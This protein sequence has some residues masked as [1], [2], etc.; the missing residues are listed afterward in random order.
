MSEFIGG[1]H[2]RAVVE[3]GYWEQVLRKWPNPQIIPRRAFERMDKWKEFYDYLGFSHVTTIGE[4]LDVLLKYEEE[5]K[6]AC[7]E[8]GPGWPSVPAC[9]A[10]GLATLKADAKM[11]VA[12]K[13]KK[14][15]E[16]WM[17]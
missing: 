5:L 11:S 7:R 14:R 10:H 12:R 15:R 1:I 3:C 6:Q 4:N 17:W 8:Q 9:V 2:Q 16:N 13:T